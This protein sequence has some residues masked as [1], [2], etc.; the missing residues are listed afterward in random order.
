MA[1]GNPITYRTA[2][3][4]ASHEA[5]VRQAY[6]DSVGVW[7]WSVGLT[8]A[9]GHN[10][11]RYIG[12]PQTME[13]CLRI[14]VWALEE[15][16]APAVRKAFAGH[17]LT[18]AQFAAALSFHWNT[19]AISRASWVRLW[20]EGKIAEAKKAFMDWSRPAE[21]VPRRQKERDLFFDG[22]WSNNGTITEYTRVA[23][24]GTP[25]WSSAMRVNIEADLRVALGQGGAEP[26]PT[27]AEPTPEPP[28]PARTPAAIL[29]EIR[30]L[31]DELETLIGA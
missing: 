10:V 7:T 11:E 29:A 20:K 30:V 14:Y 27:P 26:A 4:I 6:K 13:H 31:Q 28:A 25:V 8:N 22:K 1:T 19:G 23:A 15:K 17:T 24:S 18:E 12:K 9:T 5:I 3:E 2:L 16:Y 21:I